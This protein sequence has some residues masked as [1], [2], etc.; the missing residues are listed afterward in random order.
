VSSLVR[1]KKN[2]AAVRMI[3]ELGELLR[4]TMEAGEKQEV[5]LHEDLAVAR[6]YLNVERMRFG[7]KL[8]VEVEAPADVADGLVPNLLL[9][10]LVENAVKHGISRR[11][12]PGC[13]RVTA[14]RAGT[15]LKV[16][17]AD[18]G[19]GFGNG[20]QP[21]EGIGLSNTRSRLKAL[22]GED[23]S[24]TIESPAAG[25]TTV[26]IELPWR[27]RAFDTT[28]EEAVAVE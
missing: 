24:F 28:A 6:H 10:P 9:Q 16:S 21:V 14:A 25:G 7:D 3:A 8:R 22:Y 5:T 17:V 20:R 1:Q 23:Y 4:F 27:S 11:L 12:S 15:R 13:V 18:D 26:S 2:D 19:P